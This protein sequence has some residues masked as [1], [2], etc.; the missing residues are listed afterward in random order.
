MCV[1]VL[2]VSDLLYFIDLISNPK[3]P[4]ELNVQIID[5]KMDF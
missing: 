4:M 1:S 5:L 2:P 3:H